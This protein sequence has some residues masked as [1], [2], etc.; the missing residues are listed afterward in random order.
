MIAYARYSIYGM[1]SR[2]KRAEGLSAARA[3]AVNK[4]EVNH[5]FAELKAVLDKNNVIDSPT[6][7]WN[8]DES[9]LQDVFQSKR[10]VGETGKQL[11][12]VQSGEKGVHCHP[13][14]QCGWY[15]CHTYGDIQRCTTQT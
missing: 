1:L 12:Q 11:Y 5:W 6:H 2:A 13:C 8:V 10:A 4:E 9:G 7:L 3:Q 15:H 14:I